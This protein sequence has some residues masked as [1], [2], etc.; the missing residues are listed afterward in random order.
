MGGVQFEELLASLSK[1]LNL[2]TWWDEDRSLVSST[3]NYDTADLV[4]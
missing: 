2:S 1:A 4:L 3:W